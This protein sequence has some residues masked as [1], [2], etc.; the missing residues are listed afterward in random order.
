MR[1]YLLGDLPESEATSLEQEFF[2]DDGKFDEMWEIESN[3]VEGYVRG[4]L[5][6]DD[7]ERFERHY[8][9]SP[10]HRQRV[11]VVRNLIK[12]ADRS[13]TAATEPKV[14][15]R[16][17]LFE[18]PGISPARWRFALAAAVLL[19][20]VGGLWLFIDRVHLRNEMAELKAESEA[21]RSREQS[22]ADQMAAAQGQSE[23]LATELERLRAERDA[24]AQHA[25]PAQIQRPAI[26]SFLLSPMLIR[27]SG[28]PQTLT[29]PLKTDGVHLR[30]RV[31]QG[32]AR[33]FQASVRAVE[34]RHIWKQTIKHHTDGVSAVITVQIP[35]ARLALGDYFLTLST[36]NPT[37]ETEEVNRYFFRVIRQ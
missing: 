21:R 4:R 23:K 14:S 37:G 25:P 32:D 17:R 20:A 11:A 33:S 3:L 31:E 12:K 2:T 35:A 19:L 26:F 6:S 27:G 13:R 18:M 9:A 34:G 24:L 22:L 1:L 29:I 10:V 8:L 5:S 7:R 16:G 30:M 36:V 15:L 28:D